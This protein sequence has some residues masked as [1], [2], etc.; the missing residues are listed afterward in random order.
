MIPKF[1][2][3]DCPVFGGIRARIL[4]ADSW[5]SRFRSLARQMKNN[6]GAITQ[7]PVTKKLN[8]EKNNLNNL[9]DAGSRLRNRFGSIRI[10]V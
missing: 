8:H 7:R 1:W 5:P 3:N 4:L 6:V 9:V 2:G 10:V